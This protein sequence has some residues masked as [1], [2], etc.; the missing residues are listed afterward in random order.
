MRKGSVAESAGTPPMTPT[1]ASSVNA[2]KTQVRTAKS[3]G[4]NLDVTDDKTRDKCIEL[5]YDA[6]ASDSGARKRRPHC[7]F[8]RA[9]LTHPPPQPT[10]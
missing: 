4:V 3:D 8:A 7:P 1:T 10:T 9:R 6:L 5:I 2:F